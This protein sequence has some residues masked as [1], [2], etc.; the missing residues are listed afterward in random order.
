MIGGEKVK[1]VRRTRGQ[2]R[3]RIG[4]FG[5]SELSVEAFCRRVARRVFTAGALS[6]VLEA[7]RL[8]FTTCETCIRRFRDAGFTPGAAG[9]GAKTRSR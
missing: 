4:R 5:A 7:E 8:W 9:P 3:A 2:W 6:S 1:G